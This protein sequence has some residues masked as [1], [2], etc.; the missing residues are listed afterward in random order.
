MDEKL[1]QA[2]RRIEEYLNRKKLEESF[3]KVQVN[4]DGNTDHSRRDRS[5]D[6]HTG[7]R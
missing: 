4:K 3:L 1:K 6:G 7:G 2:V 5:G